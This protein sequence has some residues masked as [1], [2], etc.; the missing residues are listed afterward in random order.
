MPAGVVYVESSAVLAWLLGESSE[1]EVRAAM[2]VADRLVT[3]ALTAVECSRA[4]TRARLLGGITRVEELAALQLLQRAEQ[5]WDVHALTEA[6]LLRARA[7]MP[8]DPVR[9]RD[10]LHVATMS[11][12][13][14]HVGPVDVLSLDVRVRSCATALGFAVVP[15]AIGPAAAG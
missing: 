1:Q 7:P 4:L 8:S 2:D 15:D 5:G 9:T 10:A 14:E 12:L 6:V 11:A 13:R 3:S